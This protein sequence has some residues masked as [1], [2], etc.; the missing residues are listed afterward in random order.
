MIGYSVP[1]HIGSAARVTLA[2]LPD[3]EI[4]MY[5]KGPLPAYTDRS[6]T[7]AKAL[8]ENIQQIREDRFARV[9]ADH[10]P[11]GYIDGVSFPVLDMEGLPHAAI[12]VTGPAHR[13]SRE[14][15]DDLLPSMLEAIDELHEESRLYSSLREPIS[16]AA[17][18]RVLRSRVSS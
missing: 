15:I 5:L 17:R 8:W 13:F 18:P 7:S 4:D 14:R 16:P 6:L 9:L 2:F 10:T 3:Y 11:A 1:L 12:S